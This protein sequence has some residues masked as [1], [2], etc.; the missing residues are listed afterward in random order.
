[1][2][3]TAQPQNAG[4]VRRGLV[5][6]RPA[7]PAVRPI[8]W[9]RKAR[10]PANQVS[11]QV[12]VGG[13]PQDGKTARDRRSSKRADAGR[14]SD[15][16]RCDFRSWHQ[17]DL[18][19]DAVNVPSSE[20]TGSDWPTAKP[21]LLTQACGNQSRWSMPLAVSNGENDSGLPWLTFS[22]NLNPTRTLAPGF[23]SDTQP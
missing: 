2:F 16:M 12:L 19:S 14:R 9:A 11:Q 15:R 17:A 22:H 1:V 23:C 7:C 3:Q 18:S 20:T 6:I 5:P 8:R 10:R 13:E 4:C 21:I